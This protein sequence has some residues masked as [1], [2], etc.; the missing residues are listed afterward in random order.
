MSS[1]ATHLLGIPRRQ[2]E[3]RAREIRR[4]G[5]TQKEPNNDQVRIVIRKGR[6]H[7][8]GSPEGDKSGKIETRSYAGKDQVGRDLAEDVADEEDR[9]GSVK[10]IPD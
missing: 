1:F 5:D 2:Q 7:A 9:D 10:L 4:L 8:D 6:R 3:E